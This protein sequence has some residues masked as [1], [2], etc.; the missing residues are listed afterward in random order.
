MVAAADIFLVLTTHRVFIKQ[1]DLVI[2]QILTVDFPIGE[3]LLRTVSV[4]PKAGTPVDRVVS[5]VNHLI[6]LS[7]PGVL[8]GAKYLPRFGIQIEHD[9]PGDQTVAD[10]FVGIFHLTTLTH[11]HTQQAKNPPVTLTRHTGIPVAGPL[12]DLR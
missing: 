1:R 10:A 4:D 11:V 9:F 2:N 7:G 3:S 8:E 5:N 6:G 12:E